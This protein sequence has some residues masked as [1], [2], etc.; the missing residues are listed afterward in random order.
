MKSRYKYQT[1]V[2]N[3]VEN[4]ILNHSME[5]VVGYCDDGRKAFRSTMTF[6]FVS[7][8]AMLHYWISGDCVPY[9]YEVKDE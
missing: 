4:L 6:P 1:H 8:D 9:M 3:E 5:V 7:P 2:Y